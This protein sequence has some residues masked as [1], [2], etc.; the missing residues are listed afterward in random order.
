[1]KI[2]FI[3]IGLTPYYNQVLNKLS[4]QTGVE[5]YNLVALNS[6]HHG[7]AGVYQTTEDVRFKVLY[8]KYIIR[9][10]FSSFHYES[11]R[12][13]RELLLELRPD[14]IVSSE[15][16]LYAFLYEAKLRNTIKEL[17]IKIIMKDIPFR[18]D[19]YNNTKKEIKVG[20]FDKNFVSRPILY[21]SYICERVKLKKFFLAVMRA[22]DFLKIAG[23]YKRIFGRKVLLKKLE[24]KK[25]ILNFVDAHVDYV[26]DA[27]RLFHSYGVPKEKIFIIYNSPDTDYLFEVRK[28]IEKEEFIL[29]PN[30]HRLLH[31]GRLVEW[32]KVDLLIHALQ[33]IKEEFKDA[34][35]L[36]IGCGPQEK[37][38]RE[39]AQKLELEDAVRFLGGIY[40]SED[41]G[42]YFLSSSLYVLAGMGGISLND[43]MIFGK[44]VICSVCDGTEKKLV[45]DGVNG[46][47]F[48]EGDHRDLAR[49]IKVLF[50]DPALLT[51]MGKESTE[52][53]KRDINIHT[54]IGGY[55][56]AFSY[57]LGE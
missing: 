8:L 54:V 14:I 53:I 44:P 22:G 23:L 2:L 24:T 49:K 10:K 26:E 11:F 19:T 38:L 41:L 32:K 17:G 39:L 51:K 33:E 3:G 1:M 29:P 27:Y 7:G 57:V 6:A 40:K 21:L 16:Y 42:R 20:N 35:V 52:I 5:V 34:E 48:K 13:L 47:Y 55:L 4:E 36:V 45:Y 37:Y 18:L 50:R 12:K 30:A 28:K 43:A 15:S 9:K 31:V 56:R 25:R 46:F